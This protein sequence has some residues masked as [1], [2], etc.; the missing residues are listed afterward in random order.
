MGL[1]LEYTS[2]QTPIDE[3]ERDGLL[4]KSITTR[5]DLDE[6]EQLNIEKAVE[7]TLK[8]K[9]KLDTILEADFVFELHRQ[10]LDDVWAW[11]GKPRTSNKNIGVDKHE[12]RVHLK[13]LLDDCKVWIDQR[14]FPDDEIAVRFKHRLVSIHIFPNGNGRHSRLMADVLVKHGLNRLVFSWGSQRAGSGVAIREEYLRALRKADAGSY[15]DLLRFA[16]AT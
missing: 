10:M 16:R 7:W 3:D 6:F 9:F 4:I 5:K 8:R 2:G 11:A 14:V 15:D 13:D 1:D 12:I